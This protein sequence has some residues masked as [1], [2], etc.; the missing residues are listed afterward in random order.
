MESEPYVKVS[1]ERIYET[2]LEIKDQVGPLPGKVAALEIKVAALER[3]R[4]TAAGAA[5]TLGAGVGAF[6]VKTLGG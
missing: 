3:W 2:L 6:L 5:S 1:L 4:W